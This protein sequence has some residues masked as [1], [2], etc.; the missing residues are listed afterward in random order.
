VVEIRHVPVSLHDSDLGV[1]VA[2][3]QNVPDFVGQKRWREARPLSRGDLQA[4][5]HDMIIN[6]AAFRIWKEP[7]LKNPEPV[8]AMAAPIPIETHI[9]NFLDCVK[10]RQE[11]NA[12][13][14]IGASAVSA[15]HLANVA[16]HQERQV[17]V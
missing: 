1:A 7:W 10:S 16:F 2:R 8:Q 14:E 6:N 17:R 11:P 5:V 3:F 4:V 12:P 15:P 9:Q 13:V